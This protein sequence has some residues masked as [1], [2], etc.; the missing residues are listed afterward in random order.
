MERADADGTRVRAR[1]AAW[2]WAVCLVP[3]AGP[4]LAQD[5]N[6]CLECHSLPDQEVTFG[7][8]E[9]R[10]VTVDAAAFASSAHGQAGLDCASCHAGHEEYPHPPLAEGDARDYSLARTRACADCH[11]DQVK[12]F[13]DG[14]HSQMLQAGN[15]KAAAC[16]DCHDPH[17][18]KR[19]TRPEGGG[20]LPEARVAVPRTCARCH[21]SIFEQYSGSAHGAALIGQGNPDVPT[22]I[23][24]HGVHRIPDPRTARFR[25]DSPKMC[26]ACHTDASKM[27]RYGLSTAVLNTYV[28]DFHGS[29][30]TLFQKTRP[31]QQTNKPV[32]YDCHGIHDIPHTRDPAKG[33]HVKANLLRT[34]QQCHP[35]ATANFPDAWMSHF[36][37][38]REKTPLVYWTGWVYRILIPGTIGGMLVFVTADFVRRRIDA[39]RGRGTGEPS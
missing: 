18:G 11:D 20:L 3:V 12:Q 38:D 8:G 15:R 6:A 36:I 14:V 21:S 16:I 35:T 23:D 34:C 39:R 19:L 17:S 24:C 1:A 29:T 28:S 37:P 33:I 22:C 5:A 30:V 4:A 9:R 32:C 2:L 31:D 25:L 26:S 13:A 7:N 10:S 27:A